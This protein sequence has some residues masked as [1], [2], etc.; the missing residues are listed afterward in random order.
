MTYTEKLKHPKWQKKRLMVLQ[1]DGFQCRQC[2]SAERSLEVHHFRYAKNP[3]DVED[4]FLATLCSACHEDRQHVD[5]AAREAL[6]LILSQSDLSA[7]TELADALAAR[8]SE[9]THNLRM[10]M[11]LTGWLNEDRWVSYAE[12][13]PPHRGFVE[14]VLGRILKWGKSA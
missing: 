10:E 11:S 9:A 7:A 5:D 3:W 4:C 6:A 12:E 8:A 2:R 1:R 13:Y 14:M